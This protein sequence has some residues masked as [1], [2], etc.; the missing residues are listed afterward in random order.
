MDTNNYIDPTTL[1]MF[2]HCDHIEADWLTCKVKLAILL[3]YIFIKQIIMNLQCVFM[4]PR[5]GIHANRIFGLCALTIAG[6]IAI[7]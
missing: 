3:F 7:F 4:T 2:G 5:T 6:M 1:P